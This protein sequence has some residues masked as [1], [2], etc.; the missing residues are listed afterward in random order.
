MI[1]E[2]FTAQPTKMATAGVHLAAFGETNE[3]Y[4]PLDGV[5]YRSCRRCGINMRLAIASTTA[6]CR[7]CMGMEFM[8]RHGRFNWLFEGATT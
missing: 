4:W 1:D 6:L 2:A 5:R 3:A 7:D 8:V